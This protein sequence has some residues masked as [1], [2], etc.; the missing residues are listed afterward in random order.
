MNFFGLLWVISAVNGFLSPLDI[1]KVFQPFSRVIP[2]QVFLLFNKTLGAAA[3]S[4]VLQLARASSPHPSKYRQTVAIHSVPAKSVTWVSSPKTFTKTIPPIIQVVSPAVSSSAS[5]AAPHG[6]QATSAIFSHPF[7]WLPAKGFSSRI[8]DSRVQGGVAKL[9]LE[10]PS[11]IIRAPLTGG[12]PL[13]AKLSGMKEPSSPI[14]QLVDNLS[15]W[16]EGI[17]DIFKYV[18]PPI[19]V[20]PVSNSCF[21]ASGDELSAW[22]TAEQKRGVASEFGIC[23]GLWN[24]DIALPVPAQTV[25]QVRLRDRM[26]AEVPTEAQAEQIARRLHQVIH[27][28]QFD[29]HSL[30]PSFVD[31][32]PVGKAGDEVLFWL[33]ADSAALLDRNAELAVIDWINNLRAAFNVPTL[34]LVAAQSYLHQLVPTEQ[35]IEGV[36]S[37]YGPDFH[38]RLTATGEIYNQHDLTAAHPSLP[39]DTYLQVTN[40]LT[41]KQVIVRINDR[42]PYFGDRS[43]DLSKEAARCLGSEVNGIVPYEAV[44]MQSADLARINSMNHKAS[45]SLTHQQNL[46]ANRP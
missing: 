8:S 16:S 21:S 31:G 24:S 38:G 4:P 7:S 27:Q 30:Q 15:R 44:V 41:G 33:D 22:L 13:I 35:R 10:V 5:P 11:S 42:G 37:W 45:T 14:V 3:P 40:Q 39:F 20:V 17:R 28:S 36:A 1:P 9:Y 6:F 25:F 46:W 26:I 43:L 29:P 32:L 18:A 12:M 2:S 23:T 34:S 19:T